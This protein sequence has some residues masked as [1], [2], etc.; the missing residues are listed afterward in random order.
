MVQRIGI[1]LAGGESR[2]FGQ[3]KA[4]A[5]FKNKPFYAYVF[6]ALR[7]FMDK[8]IVVSHPTLVDRFL[9]DPRL[10]VISDDD[11]Y[12]G[13]G[14][15]A[16][17]YTVM[18]QEEAD[19]FFLFPCDTPLVN[20]DLVQW[21]IN[22]GETHPYSNGIVPVVGRRLQPL[23]GLYRKDCFP[24]LE[25]FLQS[26]LLKVKALIDQANLLKVPADDL[27]ASLFVNV[28]TQDEL[29]AIESQMTSD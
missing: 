21:L 19:E 11:R 4:F 18:A 25:N 8:L 29:K 27:P 23:F 1:L 6:E 24:Y 26:N 14:P 28:N 10:Q 9:E 5:L 17:L 13:K 15:L 16:G 7:P 22:L 12:I 3:P 2:R 20:S